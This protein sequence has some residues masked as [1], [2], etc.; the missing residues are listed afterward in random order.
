[1]NTEVDDGE[2]SEQGVG[3]DRVAVPIPTTV[4]VKPRQAKPDGKWNAD[5]KRRHAVCERVD[6]PEPISDFRCQ[7]VGE[8]LHFRDGVTCHPDVEEKVERYGEDVDPSD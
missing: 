2:C 3:E 6:A 7:G 8:G 5:V 4:I 1:M